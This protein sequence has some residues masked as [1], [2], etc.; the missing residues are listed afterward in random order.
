LDYYICAT[1]STDVILKTRTTLRAKN[2]KHPITPIEFCK[3]KNTLPSQIFSKQFLQQLQH[4][5]FTATDIQSK[6]RLD[7]FLAQ[8]IKVQMPEISRSRVQELIGS[9]AVT[10]EGNPVTNPSLKIKENQQFTIAIPPAKEMNLEPQEID[11]E[12]AFEDENMLVINK[13][14]GLITHPGNGNHDKTLVNALLFH[15]RDAAGQLNLSGINGVLRPGIVHRL[16]KDTSGLMVVAKN[17]L[18]HQNLAR[19]I[20]NRSLKRNYLALCHG[21]PK[22]L[23]GVIDKNIGRS[24]I[25]RLKMAIMNS[26]GRHAITHYEVQ[27]IYFDGAFCAVHCQ[28]DTGRTHQ[29]RVHLSNIGHSIAGDVT[30]GRNKKLAKNVAD[31]LSADEEDF[32]KNFNRQALHSYK[33]AFAHPVS[34]QEMVFEAAPPSDMQKLQRIFQKRKNEGRKN[35]LF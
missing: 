35:G 9:G 5:T 22:P 26:G 15:C 27:E 32:V 8:Q 21:I 14:T 20:A 7:Q 6:T 1:S 29:I 34:G 11:F 10:Q 3:N 24:K 31:A 12:V 13:P 19:Q 25:N 2:K 23:K 28:L 4:F 17:D 16:D 30:Y 33:I 18:A